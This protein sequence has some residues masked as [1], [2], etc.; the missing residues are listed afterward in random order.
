MQALTQSVRDS[1]TAQ[2][3]KLLLINEH[4]ESIDWQDCDQLEFFDPARLTLFFG[5]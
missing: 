3:T 5:K 2:N 1:K 4:S